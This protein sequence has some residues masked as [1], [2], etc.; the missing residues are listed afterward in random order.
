MC[1]K[2]EVEREL[3]SPIFWIGLYSWES[4]LAGIENLRRSGHW[5]KIYWS[6]W[7]PHYHP[8]FLSEVSLFFV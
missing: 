3:A 1:H 5:M 8:V 2:S 4:P 7:L 6:K